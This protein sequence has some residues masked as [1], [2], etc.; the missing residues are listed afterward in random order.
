M[1]ESNITK[2]I[3]I[4][5]VTYASTQIIEVLMQLLTLRS[6][7][8]SKSITIVY[9]IS[10]LLKPIALMG[11]VIFGCKALTIILKACSKLISN[12]EQSS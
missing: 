6:S 12:N 8:V 4:S 9:F 5:G 7:I 10:I 11:L 2:G 1:K 3:F